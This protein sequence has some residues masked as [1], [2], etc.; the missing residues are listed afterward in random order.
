MHSGPTALRAIV[1][2]HSGLDIEKFLVN[3]HSPYLFSPAICCP[4]PPFHLL[5]ID[6]LSQLD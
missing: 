2:T 6:R 1:I 3:S 5:P 4:Y